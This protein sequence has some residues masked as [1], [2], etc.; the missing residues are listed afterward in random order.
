MKK[1]NENKEIS[2]R[3]ELR[4]NKNK[5]KVIAA[6]VLGAIA[7]LFVIFLIAGSMLVSDDKI[8]SGVYVG[9]TDLGGMSVQSAE[10]ALLEFDE[11]YTIKIEANKKDFS[12][13]TKEAMGVLDAKQTAE[14]AFSYGKDGNFFKRVFNAIGTRFNK[15]EILPV[16]SAFDNDILA[17]KISNIGAKAYEPV[18][19][20]TAAIEGESIVLIPGKTGYDGNPDSAIA[21]FE[22]ALKTE[23]NNLVKL[24]FSIKA[25]D[26]LTVEKLHEI[27]STQGLDAT[28][29]IEN[30]EVT[31]TEA[32]PGYTFDEA[33]AI[34][35]IAKLTEDGEMLK[36]PCKPMPPKYT[37]EEL[38]A[39]LFNKDLAS[40]STRY[41]AGQANRSANV[42]NAASKINGK[43]ILPG[44]VFSF[45]Q[46][47]GKRTVANG[48]KPAPE[49]V[50]G[51]S[52]TG[53]GGGTCQVST[54][55]YSAVLYANLEVV[56]RRNHS[57]SVSYVPLG[58]DATVTDGG[59]DFKFKNNTEYPVKIKSS[60]SGGKITVTIVGTA[61][62]PARTVKIVNTKTSDL[63]ATTTRIVYDEHGDELYREN[64]GTSKYKPHGG[65]E[66][67]NAEQAPTPA[68]SEAPAPSEEPTETKAPEK[69]EEPEKTEAPKE[70][71]KPESTPAVAETEAPK[72]TETPKPTVAPT[73]EVIEEKAV[74]EKTE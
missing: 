62:E 68:P 30:G 5:P 37:T 6:S 33:E 27:L 19:E 40:Y 66:A 3:K 65:E 64:M 53:I 56:S 16:F 48:F 49:Y 55:L 25:P 58:Q 54:T 70:T 73:P 42:A 74:Q 31:V 12:L 50:N 47:V 10:K 20:H 8:A 32:K 28:F 14:K 36:I 52:V 63:S 38:K 2:S 45:N 46:T 1:E 4:K 21:M 13:D 34:A 24:D 72:P 67:T 22:D 26:A 61:P 51:Q 29:K 59:I 39:K 9:N 43:I 69:T 71:E 17:E 18:V 41:N 15:K 11:P 7:A 60:A 35:A 57:M 44:E 23:Y